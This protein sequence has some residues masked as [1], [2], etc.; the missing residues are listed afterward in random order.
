M[1][2]KL[3]ILAILFST[4]LIIE[5][6][7]KRHAILEESLEEHLKH[8]FISDEALI[9][10]RNKRQAILDNGGEAISDEPLEEYL[11]RHPTSEKL[12]EED[13]EHTK[14]QKDIHEESLEGSRQKRQSKF[15]DNVGDSIEVF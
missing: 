10:E 9:E 12:V 3:L 2:F 5:S 14:H 15:Q 8:Q 13:D 7:Y 1:T 11:I 6:R 4:A